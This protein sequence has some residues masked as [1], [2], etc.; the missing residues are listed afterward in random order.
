MLIYIHGYNSSGLSAKARHYQRAFGREQ[1]FSPTLPTDSRLAL[2]TLEQ[3]IEQF[4]RLNGD[5]ASESLGLIGSSLGGFWAVY[6]A[7]LFQLP[8]V[9]INPAIPPW[10][11]V[12]ATTRPGSFVWEAEMLKRLAPFRVET[13]SRSLQSRICLL[14]QLDDEVLDPKLALDYLPD[15]QVHTGVGGGHRLTNVADYDEIVRTFFGP[16]GCLKNH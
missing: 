15:A 1:V 11:R 4:I 12:E 14:Q 13:P 10:G 7:E 9:L 16:F 8:A 3:L 6:L 2:D 5:S